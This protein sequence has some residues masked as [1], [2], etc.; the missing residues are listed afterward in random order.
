MPMLQL[1]V[2]TFNRPIHSNCNEA[3]LYYFSLNGVICCVIP[4][5]FHDKSAR[6][7]HYNAEP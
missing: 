6:W 1:R 7:Q 5:P 3:L 2:G 4:W